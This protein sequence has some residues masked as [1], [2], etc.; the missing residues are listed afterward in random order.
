MRVRQTGRR[1]S[2]RD[3]CLKM[4]SWLFCCVC[5]LCMDVHG[6][7]SWMDKGGQA[8][9][10]ANCRLYLHGRD[11]SIC[12]QFPA[13][14]RTNASQL[15]AH[16]PGAEYCFEKIGTRVQPS[17]NA[18][19]V[20]KQQGVKAPACLVDRAIVISCDADGRD[21][22]E[23]ERHFRE[24]FA[25]MRVV[26]S[27]TEQDLQAGL[28]DLRQTHTCI[29]CTAGCRRPRLS[30]AWLRIAGRCAAPSRCQTHLRR[31]RTDRPTRCGSAR[32]QSLVGRLRCALHT[33]ACTRAHTCAQA[34]H[35]ARA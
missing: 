10:D 11:R 1:K 33:R 31:S 15:A 7:V 21:C 19:W 2:G 28:F 24:N 35:C 4:R 23:V 16:R 3:Q 9:N 13:R 18:D 26:V 32:P 25:S 5:V 20:R 29:R 34:H 12:E 30:R 6:A 8:I 14:G 22:A 17:R 27:P